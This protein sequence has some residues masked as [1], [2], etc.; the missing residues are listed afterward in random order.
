MNNSSIHPPVAYSPSIQNILIGNL[1]AFLITDNCEWEVTVSVS[2]FQIQSFVLLVLMLLA[3][4]A[5]S[6]TGSITWVR[7]DA[8][9]SG[10]IS[11]LQKQFQNQVEAFTR[12]IDQYR[13]TSYQAN[14]LSFLDNPLH[15]AS[16]VGGEWDDL[17][18]N[19]QWHFF[20]KLS[21]K[22]REVQIVLARI[23]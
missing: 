14:A 22:N 13:K 7:D 2:Q 12:L 17:Y 19:Q 23:D 4:G 10:E 20:R 11:E 21:L 18:H 6:A 15:Q 5:S 9:L 8:G 16:A 1:S 3:P